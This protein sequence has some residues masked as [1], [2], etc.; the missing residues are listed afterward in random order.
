MT[1]CKT[2]IT[3]LPRILP[4]PAYQ[5]TFLRCFIAE[6]GLF[7]LCTKYWFEVNDLFV[8]NQMALGTKQFALPD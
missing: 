8:L 3:D 4:L 1:F 6:E 5:V 2:S 7:F